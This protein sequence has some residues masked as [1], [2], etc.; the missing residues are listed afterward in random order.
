MY[1]LQQGFLGRTARLSLQAASENDQL[2]LAKV[3]REPVCSA[4]FFNLSRRVDRRGRNGR[5]MLGDQ[6][7]SRIDPM[8]T[9][10]NTAASPLREQVAKTLLRARKLPSGPYKKDLRQLGMNLLRLYKLG[11]RS[12]EMFGRVLDR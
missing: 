12:H 11:P 6:T 7:L 5:S 1:E 9:P 2:R 3:G 8:D 4:Y 10:P